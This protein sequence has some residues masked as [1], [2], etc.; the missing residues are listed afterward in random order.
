M[1]SKLYIF[2]IVYFKLLWIQSTGGSQKS[3]LF[4]I[5]VT[6]KSFQKDCN[7]QQQ[8]KK[9]QPSAFGSI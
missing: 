4:S 2:Y 1:I 5:T 9:K 7:E 3:K 6:E 8:E